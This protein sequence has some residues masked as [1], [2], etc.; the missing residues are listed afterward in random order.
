MT[1]KLPQVY[2]KIILQT[3][4]FYLCFSFVTKH[5]GMRKGSTSR[6]DFWCIQLAILAVL[7]KQRPAQKKTTKSG[8]VTH[9]NNTGNKT[10]LEN[11]RNTQ[12]LPHTHTKQGTNTFKKNTNS[13]TVMNHELPS[14]KLTWQWK[15]GLLKMYPY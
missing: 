14:G 3:I 5:L 9:S 13:T 15:M 10:F 6:K 2:Y 12:Q 1:T 11:T 7:P 8:H 4:Q